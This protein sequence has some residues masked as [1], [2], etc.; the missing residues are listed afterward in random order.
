LFSLSL[1][2]FCIRCVVGAGAKA[3]PTRLRIA[4]LSDCINDPLAQKLKWKLK[5]YNV[6]AEDI[7]SIFSIEKP[8][9]DLLPLAEEQKNAPQVITS[10]HL[11]FDFFFNVLSV[12][13]LVLSFF[14]SF[15]PFC[16]FFFGSR[17]LELLITF[18]F[19]LFLYSELHHLSL[20]K[21]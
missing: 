20:V 1:L 5:K 3:D 7:M 17:I 4:P 18:V 14:R 10:F 9:C 19:V 21:H 16:L 12:F 6:A 8:V 13:S 11:L 2:L 15:V